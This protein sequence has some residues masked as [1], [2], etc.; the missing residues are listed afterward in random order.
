TMGDVARLSERGEGALYKT[1]GVNAE[2]LI[3]HAWGWEPT[4]IAMI[5]K[6]R[7]ESSS[8]SSGQVLKEPYD[9]DKGRLIVREMTEL[10][11]LEL[12]KK[13]LVTKKME[14][15]ISYDRE[16]LRVLVPGQTIQDTVYAVAKTGKPY[17]GTVTADY[18]GRP[19]PKH[20]HGTGNIDRCTNSTRRIMQAV[21][22]VF[23]RVVDPELLIRRVNIAA[24][25]LIDEREAPR[26]TP[27]QLDLFTDY[28]ALEK[29]REAEQAADEKEKKLQQATL[30]LQ[31]KY[32]KN[33][34]LKGMNLLEGG[35]TIE[36]N[37]QIGGHRAGK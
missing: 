7:P 33:A 25:G 12:V 14:L 31:S 3:D 28:E 35:T 20:A 5:K 34:V 21:L 2:L 23:D 17:T 15:T 13:R 9:Y 37:G 27:E 36:R 18:Y 26:E 11:A 32:G 6:Y 8:L 16:S 22:E 1:F 19:A 4:T 10:L 24:L 29:Q 30:L